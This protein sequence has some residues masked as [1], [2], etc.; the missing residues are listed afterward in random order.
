MKTKITTI[1]VLLITSV[2]LF[3]DV[4]I[5]RVVSIVNGG[6]EAVLVVQ[7]SQYTGLG[8]DPHDAVYVYADFR[9]AVDGDW[10]KIIGQRIGR[11]QYKTATGGQATVLGFRG[12]AIPT[13]RGRNY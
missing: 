6:T 4:F 9:N 10:F 5:G 13:P 3:G 11:V 2:S 12:G 7:P 1:L 8:P